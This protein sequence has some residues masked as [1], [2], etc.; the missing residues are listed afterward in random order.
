MPYQYEIF[1]S[2]P[3]VPMVVKWLDRF[4]EPL[5]T[6]WLREE[7]LRRDLNM[8]LR[9]FRDSR[10]I[11]AGER[12]PRALREAARDSRCALAILMPSYFASDYCRAEWETFRVRGRES[13]RDLLVPIRF[14]DCLDHRIAEQVFDLSKYTAMVEDTPRWVEFHDHVRHL[15]GQVADRII[16]A[17]TYPADPECASWLCFDIPEP[18]SPAPIF[19]GSL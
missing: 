5:F 2:Y 17:P 19:P 11:G 1:L 18:P 12:W 4:F 7:L 15:A 10:D 9:I 13:K 14:H 16:N 6:Q 8:K 3:R